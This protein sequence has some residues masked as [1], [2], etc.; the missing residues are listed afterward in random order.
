MLV[1]IQRK[2]GQRDQV[3][4]VSFFQR[5]Q[6][7]VPCS[8][9]DHIG[10][11]GQMAAGRS[12]PD[13]IMIAPL[14]IHR[15]IVTQ[16]I[17]DHMRPRPPV[18]DIPDDVQMIDDQLLDQVAQRFDELLRPPDTD[19]RMDDLVVVGFLILYFR[20]LRDQFF[21]N[22]G[23][24]LRQRLAHLGP[25][26]LGGNPFRDLNK[27]VQGDLVPVLDRTFVFLPQHDIQLLPRIIDQCRQALLI[28][29][30][31]CIAELFVNLA[32]HGTGAVL[33][34]MIELLVLPVDIRH[35]MLRPLGQIQNRL[36]IDDLCRC[37]S[38]RRILS[39]QAL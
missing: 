9:P 37:G 11:A 31:Q 16:R 21:D 7:A 18:I 27:P 39:G 17:H 28:P 29:D 30:T 5:I 3:D 35:K 36:Q 34:D 23:K 15:V 2:R 19:D 14:H 13:D 38:N 6:I 20:L 22:I 32:P 33:Q 24:I 26:V 4:A 12:H 10:D 8:H 25:R 1:S